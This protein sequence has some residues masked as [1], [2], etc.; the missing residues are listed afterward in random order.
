MGGAPSLNLRRTSQPCLSGDA[1]KQRILVN[2]RKILHTKQNVLS[3]ETSSFQ[4]RVFGVSM[5]QRMLV[6]IDFGLSRRDP[7]FLSRR[8]LT[9]LSRRNPTFWEGSIS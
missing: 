4:Q 1:S 5:C 3:E 7:T 6:R 9:F 8:D 2:T